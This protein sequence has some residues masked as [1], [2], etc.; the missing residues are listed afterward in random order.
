MRKILSLFL[1]SLF[2]FAPLAIANVAAVETRE[3]ETNKDLTIGEEIYDDLYAS[4]DKILTLQ[5]VVGGDLFAAGADVRV[6]SEVNGDVYISGGYVTLDESIMGD[7]FIAGGNV[8]LNGNVAGSVYIAGGTVD[9]N[10]NV[11]ED[12][13]VFAG[14]LKLNAQVY[15]DVRVFSGMA[16]IKEDIQGDVISFS[17]TLKLSSDVG[18]DVHFGSGNAEISSSYIGGDLVTYD[19]TNLDLNDSITIGG[20]RIEK[21]SGME[22]DFEIGIGAGEFSLFV[23]LWKFIWN[24]VQGIGLVLLGFLAYKFTPVK[25]NKI[26]EQMRSPEQ[27]LKSF[28]VGCLALPVGIIVSLALLISVIGWPILGVLLALAMIAKIMTT[29]FVGTKLGIW[30]LKPLKTKRPVLFG[31]IAGILTIQILTAI[32]FIGGFFEFFVFFIG[33]GAILRAWYFRNRAARVGRKGK[34]QSVKKSVKKN[35]K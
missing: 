18:G 4:A 9:I 2:L 25:F 34:R 33:I 3:G 1:V 15:D 10:G 29:V 32:P 7:V 30:M 17:G 12:V 20:E 11:Y 8:E 27:K 16:E 26:L 22:S 13:M 19:N 35:G 6:E 24:F 31:M 23:G 21:D 14:T 5:K 28:G